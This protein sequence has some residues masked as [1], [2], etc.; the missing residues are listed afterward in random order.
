MDLRTKQRIAL[1][2]IFFQS[3]LCFSSW[4]SRIPHIKANFELSDSELGGVLLIRPLGALIGLPLS[5]FIVD[6]FGSKYSAIAGALAF[7]SSLV[8]I[9]LAPTLSFLIFS[10]FLFGIAAN[11]INISINAQALQVQESFGKVIMA[12]FHGVWSFAGFIGAAIGSLTIYLNL[13]LAIHF[14]IIAGMVWLLLIL[15]NGYLDDSKDSSASRKFAFEKPDPHLLKLGLVAFCGLI[16]EGCMFDWSGVYF[17]QVVGV[18]EELVAV[19]YIAFMSTMS[20]GRFISDSFTNKYGSKTIIQASGIMI[21]SGLLI[22]VVFPHISTA[23]I[24]F[25]L[26]G[27]GT[28]SVIPLTYNEVGKNKK[29]T[30][31]K[32]LAMVATL[33][34][35]GFLL[36]PPAIGFIADLLSLQ[37]SFTLVAIIGL[38]ISIII[39]YENKKVKIAT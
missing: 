25:F 13:D 1:S 22:A 16:C 29:F 28:S 36:G 6:R 9:G 35:L 34:Y 12:S 8:F 10:V 33:G 2:A 32:A 38:V 26:V 15:C 3:G 17:K 23:I 37:A 24:G 21:F 5:G 11:I 19:G 30:P 14:L 18:K 7:S 20:L 27:A 4:A 31:G 39:T